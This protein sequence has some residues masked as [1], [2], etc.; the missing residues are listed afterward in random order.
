MK[1][2]SLALALGLASP[3]FAAAP[4]FVDFEKTWSYGE[5]VADTYAAS[6]VSF[7]NV[8]GLSNDA[9]FTY[10][11]NA[12]SPLGVA[13][14]QL[15]GIVNTTAFMNVSA[16]VTGGLSFFYSTPSDAPIAI[17]AYSGLNGTGTLLGSLD[18]TA[19]SAD[20]SAWNHA[21]LSFS[22]TAMSFDLTGMANA[23]ALDNIS[24]VP[25]PGSVALMLGGAAL[26]LARRRRD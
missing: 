3:A 14:V 6:G 17:K 24:A 23:V 13:F 10:F 11:S 26:L 19:N 8:L 7:T 20:Y 9:D 12:P 21:V 4:L 18:L 15:D 25:E 2:A 1:L 5:E 16:G 22:G